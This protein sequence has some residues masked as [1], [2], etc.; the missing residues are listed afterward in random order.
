MRIVPPHV[1]LNQKEYEADVG[2]DPTRGFESIPYPDLPEAVIEMGSNGVAADPDPPRYLS[3][4]EPLGHQ[5]QE[6]Q[7]TPRKWACG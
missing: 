4:S 5:H 3:V 7:F 2:F 6:L 1:T